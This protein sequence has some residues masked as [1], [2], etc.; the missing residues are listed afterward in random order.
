MRGAFEFSAPRV[1]EMERADH[2][3]AGPLRSGFHPIREEPCVPVKKHQK[4]KGLGAC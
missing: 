3:A 4:C 2:P 1:V